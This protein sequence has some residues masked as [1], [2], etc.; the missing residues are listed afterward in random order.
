MDMLSLQTFPIYLESIEFA[1]P[2][3]QEGILSAF[4]WAQLSNKSTKRRT[5]STATA[6]QTIKFSA[7]L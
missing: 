5:E 1:S 4:T 2:A 3:I 7:M 6:R